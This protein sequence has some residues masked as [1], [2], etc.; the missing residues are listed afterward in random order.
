MKWEIVLHI[1][2]LLTSNYLTTI[3]INIFNIDTDSHNLILSILCQY[4]MGDGKENNIF[5]LGR[6]S[7][8][9]GILERN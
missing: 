9:K 5:A 6:N 7:S 1:F 8:K 3:K 4:E 2:I